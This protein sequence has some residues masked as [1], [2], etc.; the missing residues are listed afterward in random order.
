[1]FCHKEVEEPNR[2]FSIPNLIVQI[3]ENKQF[4]VCSAYLTT[5][6]I[7]MVIKKDEVLKFT[8]RVEGSADL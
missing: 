2:S 7:H 6:Y 5:N 4:E 3:K 1:M 8:H